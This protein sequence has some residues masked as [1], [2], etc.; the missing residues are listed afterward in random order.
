[1]LTPIWN[2]NYAYILCEHSS[3]PVPSAKRSIDVL[4]WNI[5]STKTRSPH[6]WTSNHNP[7]KPCHVNQNGVCGTWINNNTHII[8]IPLGTQRD[9][10]TGGRLNMNISSYQYKDHHV[11]DMSRD[12]LIFN[13]GI[14][15][16]G[17]D[18]LYIETGARLPQQEKERESWKWCDAY[19]QIPSKINMW[20]KSLTKNKCVA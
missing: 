15:I 2:I 18:G 8:R 10:I 1:M 14:P 16:P 9:R 7:M 11:K 12:R 5:L 19:E 20:P 6:T 4:F 3:I 13:M 17:K